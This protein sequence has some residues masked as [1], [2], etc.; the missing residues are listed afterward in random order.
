LTGCAGTNDPSTAALK[1]AFIFS[2]RTFFAKFGAVSKELLK[3][4]P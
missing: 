3:E 2:D 1:K 4:V